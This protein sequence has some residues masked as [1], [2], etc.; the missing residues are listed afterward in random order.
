MNERN[1]ITNIFKPEKK[2][3]GVNLEGKNDDKELKEINEMKIEKKIEK[4]DLVGKIELVKK[5]ESSIKNR[6][7]RVSLDKNDFSGDKKQVRIFNT[8]GKNQHFNRKS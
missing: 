7:K 5:K 2:K 3:F 8:L 1:T 6:Q 4:R